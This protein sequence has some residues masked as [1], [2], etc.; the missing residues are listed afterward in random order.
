MQWQL[1]QACC[2]GHRVSLMLLAKQARQL[3]HFH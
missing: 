1:K 3:W 2:K